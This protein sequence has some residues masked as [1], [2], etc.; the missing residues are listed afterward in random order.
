MPFLGGTP[1]Q[2]VERVNTPP[3][4]SPDGQRM[5]YVR[6]SVS[7]R[8]QDL[9]TADRDGGDVRTI[10]S[11][12]VFATGMPGGTMFSPA[13]ST[14][15]R[16]IAM[17]ERR[18]EDVRDIGIRVF[19][20]A[21]G[22][23][24]VVSTRGDVPLGLAW[25]DDQTLLIAQ[26]LE[27]G[28]PSQLWRVSVPAGERTKLSNDVSRYSELSLSADANTLVTSRP[29]TRVE[30]W[31]G[32]VKGAG[33]EVV[34]A[35]PFLSSAFYYATVDWDGPRL[36]FT[37]TLNGRYEI[38]RIDPEEAG[39]VPQPIVAGRESS[40]S[41]DGTIVFRAVG[42]QDG[43]W[44]VGRGGQ[45]PVELAKGSVSYP[46]ISADGRR[47]VFSSRLSGPQTV[48][49]VPTDGGAATQVVDGVVGINSFSDIAPDGKSVIFATGRDTWMICELPACSPQKTVGPLAALK[50]G[51]VGGKPR[52]A[53]DGRSFT[54]L[55]SFDPSNNLWEQRLDGSPPRQLT[56][57]S[58]G[59]TIGHYAWSRDGRR[60]AL[61][62][63]T[64][65]SD[66]V[67]FRGLEGA[68]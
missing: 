60:L 31:V 20:V 13:W 18:G 15:G 38:F 36:L 61:S 24:E 22:Q 2:I 59:K 43:L 1:K 23:S 6:P 44:K 67:L 33:R 42:G 41:N 58:D 65:S 46:F 34:R 47:V 11:G 8:G 55:D 49:Q 48:W 52:W 40:V 3:G 30:I 62:R 32:D 4:W 68:Q 45:R 64:Q 12:V 53:A 63:A 19:D 16:R 17:F 21:N 26:A 56:R 50:P 25:F 39:G 5:T 7:G 9:V 37:H 28:T 27:T 35:A 66:I 54:Y 14:D 10:A 57:F 29:E 51:A